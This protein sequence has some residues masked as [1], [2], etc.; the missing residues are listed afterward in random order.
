MTVHQFFCILAKLRK[1]WFIKV[2]ERSELRQFWKKNV[3]LTTK[4]GQIVKWEYLFCPKVG[5]GWGHKPTCAPPPL[6]K[7]GR[8]VPPL[9]PFSY[10]LVVCVSDIIIYITSPEHLVFAVLFV[11][12]NYS[13]SSVRRHVLK[14]PRNGFNFRYT[15]TRLSIFTFCDG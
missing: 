3:F 13:N 9:P 1:Y 12:S 15:F 10:A 11:G 6:L 5:W 8:H 4:Y 7:V 2:G 14:T